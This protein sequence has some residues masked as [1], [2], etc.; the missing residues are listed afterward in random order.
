[1]REKD[2]PMWLSHKP[3]VS[4]DYE[5]Q[6][7]CA[8]DA[9]F[10]SIGKST[11]DADDISAK[12]WRK[13]NDKWSRQSEELPL[14][15]VLDLAKLVIATITGK[16]SS[17]NEQMVSPADAEF[18]S[19]YINENME[20]FTPRLKELQELL[21]LANGDSTSGISEP[22]LFSFATSEL[23]QDAILAWLISW[24]DDSNKTKDE[25]MCMLG[26]S[27]LS[28]LTNIP[29]EKIHTTAVRKQW[30]NIDITVEINDNT[31]LIIED[32]TETCIHHNQDVRYKETIRKEYKDKRNTLLCTYVKT[33]NESLSKIKRIEKHGYRTVNRQ[34]ILSILNQYNGNNIIVTDFRSHLQQI[35]TM[36]HSYQSKYIKDWSRHEWQGFYKELEQHLDNAEWDYVANRSGGF[37]GLWW[38]FKSNDEVSM[39]LQFEERKLCIKIKDKSNGNQTEIR[40]KYYDIL[41]REAKKAGVSIKRPKRFGAGV[42]MTVGIIAENIIF[43][44][45]LINIENIIKKLRVY[46]QVLNNCF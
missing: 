46:E 37:W 34:A 17:L 24:A 30:K 44:N 45:V 18:L 35:E 15:R 23:S 8:G 6:D 38:H 28:L 36:T 43:G 41:M 10:L 5:K 20:L 13:S 21:I 9:K 12:I 14:W 29:A 31:I 11:W 19:S 26:K 4:V 2:I 42:Y 1:M 40:Q 22:N 32:K 16:S 25:P 33:G 39:Y 3:I 27:F 7:A